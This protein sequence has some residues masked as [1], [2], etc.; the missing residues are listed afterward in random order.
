MIPISANSTS[1][2]GVL[3]LTQERTPLG[4]GMGGGEVWGEERHPKGFIRE[5][6]DTEEGERESRAEE[7]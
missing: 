4:R 7:W 5:E 6:R 3:T 2:M 1:Q